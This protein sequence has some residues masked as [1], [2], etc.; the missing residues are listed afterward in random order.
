MQNVTIKSIYGKTLAFK[1]YTLDSARD[2]ME[3]TYRDGDGNFK[4]GMVF[5]KEQMAELR[6][7]L[8]LPVVAPVKADAGIFFLLR[9]KKANPVKVKVC[10]PGLK[11][12]K[13]FNSRAKAED[14]AR[15]LN[16]DY[17][18]WNYFVVEKEAV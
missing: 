10:W 9:Q 11:I 12:T 15:R 16:E 6:E 3:V 4:G 13:E 8:A 18:Q 14:V 17:P 5:R 1:P 7:A 2:A